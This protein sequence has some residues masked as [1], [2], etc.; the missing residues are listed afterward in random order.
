MNKFC[1]LGGTDKRKEER[2]VLIG[3]WTILISNEGIF[4]GRNLFPD[5]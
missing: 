2:E 3:R 5:D 1:D 4:K